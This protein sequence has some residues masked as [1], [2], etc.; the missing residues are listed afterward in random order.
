[1]A[2]GGG[3][4]VCGVSSR[5]SPCRANQNQGE[6]VEATHDEISSTAPVVLRRGYKQKGMDDG[7]GERK[8]D[9]WKPCETE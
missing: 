5:P 9:G 4:T 3:V 2:P 6:V 8:L 1:M 7:C